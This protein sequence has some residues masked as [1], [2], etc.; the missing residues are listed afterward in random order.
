[1]ISKTEL[2][3]QKIE[4]QI[5]WA[6]PRTVPSLTALSCI[7]RNR[8]NKN[9][10]KYFTVVGH[11]GRSNSSMLAGVAKFRTVEG[12]NGTYQLWGAQR[13]IRRVDAF[14]PEG[15]GFES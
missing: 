11:N 12:W 13:R 6:L 14:R 10:T 9:T 5:K 15:R 2:N 1:M 7:L 8:R 4:L 3:L